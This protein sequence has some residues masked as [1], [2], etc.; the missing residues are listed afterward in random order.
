LPLVLG[1]LVWPFLALCI[2][3][4]TTNQIGQGVLYKHYHYDALY[5]SKQEIYIVD[6]NL[7]DPAASL[8]FPYLTGG[9]TRTVSHHAA[10]VSGAVACVNAQFFNSTT[11]S[12]Q[13][14]R[15][16]GTVANVT[17]PAVHDEQA[18][19]DDGLRRTNSVSISF[20]PAGGWSSSTTP[21]VVSSGPDLVRNGAA[22]T[23]YDLNDGLVT[24]RNP[25]TCAAWTF[26]NHLLLTV[27][28][29]RSSAAAGMT[30]PELRDFLLSYASVRNAFNCDG[31]GSSTMWVTNT[32][33][34]VPS[35]GSQ[36]PVADGI[37]VVASAPTIPAAPQAVSVTASGT[38]I[39]LAWSTGSGALHYKVKRATA[40]GGPYA[41]L[42]DTT[43][44]T[45]TN[46]NLPAG[47]TNFYVVSSLNYIGEST[48]SIEVK[49]T[50]APPAPLGLTAVPGNGFAALSWSA[51]PAAITYK[52][53]RS[54]SSGGPYNLIV[55]PAATYFTNSGLSGHYYYV[56]SAVNASGE[57]PNSTETDV[58]VQCL[59]PSTPDG[60][61]AQTISNQISIA[62]ASAASAQGYRV[63]RA[64][65]SAGV[66][67]IIAGALVDTN[68]V[69]SSAAAQTPYFY[70]ITAYNQC[71]N[72]GFSSVVSAPFM[73]GQPMLSGTSLILGGWG[74]QPAGA[75]RLLSSTNPALPIAYWTSEAT[76]LFGA[77]GTF[78]ITNANPSTTSATFFRIE[79]LP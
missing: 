17:Q 30:L 44:L 37:A 3:T 60:L 40:A 33:V 72:S 43:Q 45:Y 75:Y 35:D 62:W 59:P 48:N 14:L 50:T 54:S 76:N 39:S 24:T 79:Q 34:N 31:G 1:L 58:V 63:Y 55:S 38:N 23:N 66:F 9:A 8:S 56:V 21:N 16:N 57:G 74:G 15:V 29:G 13:F 64:T 2:D 70:K 42:T 20:R 6:V 67:N 36:R 22:F 53:K 71:G 61:I 73:I 18:V 5:S 27:V 78:S 47:Q 7:N 41:V 19:I 12:I 32:V 69:D 52:L 77:D 10:T 26:D 25:R 51:A 46:V 68:F 11:G 28:D 4:A 65:T 49:A